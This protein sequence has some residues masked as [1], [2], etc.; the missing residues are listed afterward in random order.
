MKTPYQILDVVLDA[1]DAEIKQAYLQKV[2]EYPPDR[3]QDVF[4]SI[5]KAYSAIKNNKLRLNYSLFTLPIADFDGLINH[6]LETEQ[7]SELKPELFNKLLYASID[8]SNFLNAIDNPE[9]S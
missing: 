4:Q 5:H 8:E 7:T 6:T 9:K 3:D 1:N 2:K